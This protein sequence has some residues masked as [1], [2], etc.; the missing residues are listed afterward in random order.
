MM[1]ET[2][3][4][5]DDLLSRWHWWA[6]QRKLSHRSPYA[7]GFESYRSSRQY[8]WDSGVAD[9]DLDDRRSAQVDFEVQQM[10]EPYRSAIY[11]NARNLCTGREVWTSGRLPADRSQRELIVGLARTKLTDRL[12]DSGVI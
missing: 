6:S 5:L 9:S 10:I 1:T 12:V 3:Q 2:D 8:D 7:M 11:A 4:I